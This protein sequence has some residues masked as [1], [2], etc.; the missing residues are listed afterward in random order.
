MTTHAWRTPVARLLAHRDRLPAGLDR[1]LDRARWLPTATS[2]ALVR[3]T[4]EAAS[5][6][7]GPTGD[8]HLLVAP[9]NF[10]G[11]GFAWARAVDAHLPGTG[12]RSWTYTTDPT[13][14]FPRDHAVPMAV[15][16]APRREQRALRD[17]VAHEFDAVVIE[18]GRPLFGRLH[19]L[20]PVLEARDLAAQGL[21]VALMWHGT[22]IRIPSRHAATHP[23]SPYRSG[24]PRSLADRVRVQEGIARRNQRRS[25]AHR[26]PVLVST[27]DLLAEQ[28]HARWC[29]VVVDPGRWAVDEPPLQRPRPVVVHVPSSPWLKGTDLIEPTLRDLDA[30][31]LITYRRAERLPA[32]Q[33]RELYRSADVVLDQFRLGIYGVAACEAMAAGRLV[34]STVDGSVRRTVLV[35]TGRELPVVQAEPDRL[36]AVLESVV[37][38]RDRYQHD[39]AAGP[40]FV[41]E[42]HDGRRSARVLAQALGLS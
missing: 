14:A 1:A 22:D 16:R 17:R 8:A 6:W 24:L 5:A 27:P 40:A 21:G 37:A 20:D 15:Y 26:G 13:F 39:A 19:G 18:A 41:R 12:A 38:D 36:A 11:Q 9:A 34:V 33:V 35:Q 23:R 31:G 42:V 4:L 32:D 28:P 29:P 7:P 25:A 3:R 10:A 30:R 2:A